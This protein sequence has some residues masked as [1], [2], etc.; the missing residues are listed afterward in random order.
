MRAIPLLGVLLSGCLSGGEVTGTG[1]SLDEE[2]LK[3]CRLKGRNCP[4]PPAMQ[5]CI[6]PVAVTSGHHNAGEDCMACHASFGSRTWTVAGTLYDSAAGTAPIA[7]ATVEVI[8][9]NG[10]V[11][12]MPT[13]DNGNF[14]TTQPVALPLTVRASKCPDDVPM[15]GAASSGSCNGCHGAGSR[16]HLP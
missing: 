9:A 4:G 8:D 12:R 15:Q 16:I 1:D 2:A 11:V 13:A 14:W 10:Q 7:G 5:S 3:R 6:D